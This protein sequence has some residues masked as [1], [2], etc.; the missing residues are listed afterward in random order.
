MGDDI[1]HSISEVRIGQAKAV[2]AR[3]GNEPASRWIHGL[4]RVG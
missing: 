3:C 2:G 4:R 1:E